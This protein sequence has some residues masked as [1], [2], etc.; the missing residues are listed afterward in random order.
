M[1]SPSN[2]FMLRK[3]FFHKFSR[4]N[5][6]STQNIYESV[7]KDGHRLLSQDIWIEDSLITYCPTELDADNLAASIPTI[8][9][10]HT[11]VDMEVVAGTNNQLYRVVI[12]NEW[13]NK[14]LA[15]VDIVNALG[16][17][18]NGFACKLYQN[19]GTLISLTEGVSVRD[20]YMGLLHFQEG[21]TPVDLGYSLPLKITFFE[22]VGKT[23]E[24]F[25]N[26]TEEEL[27][28][29]T[30]SFDFAEYFVLKDDKISSKLYGTKIN[31]VVTDENGYVV[32]EKKRYL[33]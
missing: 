3:S 31:L 27:E 30:E 22:Y 28:I 29:V 18:S 7:I 2:S 21:F 19:D 26:N 25:I 6:H 15:P 23:L 5:Q 11:L 17:T 1:A 9:K 10:K 13:I 8:I 32:Y 24:E 33:Q 14:W 20:Y 16:L 12:N 4:N